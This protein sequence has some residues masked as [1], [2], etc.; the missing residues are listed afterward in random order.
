MP[1]TR[2]PVT[3]VTPGGHRLV[4]FAPKQQRKFIHRTL[5]IAWLCARDGGWRNANVTAHVLKLLQR[6][7]LTGLNLHQVRESF[8]WLVDQEYAMEVVIGKRT[9]EFVLAPD[10]HVP[11]P[12][13]VTAREYREARQAQPLSF[14]TAEAPLELPAERPADRR[15]T[16]PLPKMPPS[17]RVVFQGQVNLLRDN[18]MAWWDTNPDDAAQWV[19]EARKAL[20][21]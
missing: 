20:E 1:A 17:P 16:V 12:P 18:I 21:Q 15:V 10:V 9:R 11:K 2:P 13:S 7:G 14:E 6:E 19:A 4:T 5:M 8:S 3:P